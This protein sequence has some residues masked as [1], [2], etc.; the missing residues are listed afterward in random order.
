MSKSRKEIIER[1]REAIHR[2]AK[3]LRDNNLYVNGRKL[4][5]KGSIDMV[6]KI[7]NRRDNREN[8]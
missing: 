3:E 2:V 8:N 7:A 1:R 4:D 6:T 5:V